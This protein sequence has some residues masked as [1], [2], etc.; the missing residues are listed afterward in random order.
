MEQCPTPNRP[1]RKD[2]FHARVPL[3]FV[4]DVFAV[5]AD[6]PQHTYQVLTKRSTRLPRVA[7]KLDWPS[8]LWM[9]VSVEDS[10]ELSRVDDLRAVPA[11]VRFLSCEPLI[12]PL[13]GLDLTGIDWLIIG[14][15]SGSDSRPMELRWVRDLLRQCQ[16]PGVTTV[17]FVKQLGAVAGRALD[18]GSKGGDWER[19]PEDLRFR[20]FP[21]AV[22][23]AAAS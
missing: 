11:A 9:G 19:W 13:D 2:L 8:N 1:G 17:P 21:T 23:A 4:R 6:T 18:A 22:G 7:E 20:G 12:G 5:I 16:Q 14:G 3:G 10:R 15:E